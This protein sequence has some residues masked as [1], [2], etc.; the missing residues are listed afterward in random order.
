MTFWAVSD[1]NQSERAGFV[2]LYRKN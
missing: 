1:L 2:A